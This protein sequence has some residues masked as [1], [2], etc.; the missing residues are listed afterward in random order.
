MIYPVIGHYGKKTSALKGYTTE[1]E[2]CQCMQLLGS[3]SSSVF[4]GIR[5]NLLMQYESQKAFLITKI[6]FTIQ[7]RQHQTLRFSNVVRQIGEMCGSVECYKLLVQCLK[8]MT[9]V[10]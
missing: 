3:G 2:Q 9:R 1:D 5:S 4:W 7:N 10:R 6:N 8:L